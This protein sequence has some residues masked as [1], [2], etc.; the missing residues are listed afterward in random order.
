MIPDVTAHSTRRRAIVVRV[1]ARSGL[2][3]ALLLQPSSSA[4]HEAERTRVTLTLAADGHFTLDV[5]NDPMWLLLRLETFAGG[6]PPANM[7]SGD[8]DRRLAELTSDFADR[9]VLFVDS[10]EVRATRVDY[11]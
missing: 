1:L 2:V 7:S 9:I 10:H 8:R 6:R 5:A 11:V 4:S 3:L